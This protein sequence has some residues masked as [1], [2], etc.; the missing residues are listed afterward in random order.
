MTTPPDLPD[1]SPA[2]RTILPGRPRNYPTEAMTDEEPETTESS[3]ADSVAAA[4][5]P[6]PPG[7]AAPNVAFRLD[8]GTDFV[9]ADAERPVMFVFWAEW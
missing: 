9:L 5:K 8:D 1:P 4:P 6:V 7:P 3:T 2:T